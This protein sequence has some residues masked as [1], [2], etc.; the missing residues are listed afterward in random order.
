M[1]K[2]PMLRKIEAGWSSLRYQPQ[3]S[4]QGRSELRLHLD[5]SRTPPNGVIRLDFSRDYLEAMPVEAMDPQPYGVQFSADTITC[6]FR[7]PSREPSD[8]RIDVRHERVG[9][10]TGR[11]L[12][13]GD[14]A[15]AVTFSQ[16]V[17]P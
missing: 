6:V 3:V 10:I 12:L 9:V 5:A 4:Y 11:I 17:C 13:D 2:A 14:D 16:L 8:I 15:R 1:L 7:I